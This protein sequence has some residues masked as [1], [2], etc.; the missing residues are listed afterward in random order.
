[1]E[2]TPRFLCGLVTCINGIFQKKFGKNRSILPSGLAKRKFRCIY[3][4]ATTNYRAPRMS[5]MACFAEGIKF[6]FQIS[7]LISKCL[8]LGAFSQP[9]WIQE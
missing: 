2:W 6:I 1:M 4:V 7:V 5:E 8:N 9:K 3:G